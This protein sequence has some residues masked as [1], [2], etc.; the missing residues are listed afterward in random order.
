[1]ADSILA[2]EQDMVTTKCK[3]GDCNHKIP[4]PAFLT[5]YKLKNSQ[6]KMF[7]YV[8]SM[9]FIILVIVTFSFH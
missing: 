1:M 3:I 6:L 2:L 9:Y 5:Q 7:I 8:H 4:K